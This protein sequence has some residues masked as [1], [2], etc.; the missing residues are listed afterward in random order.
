M[1]IRDRSIP[2]APPVAAAPL[3]EIILNL[4]IDDSDGP[5]TT[6]NQDIPDI[7]IKDL[8]LELEQSD[9][10]ETDKP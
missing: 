2:V 1:C 7:E 8:G 4:E 9:D 10:T 6:Q 5:L 3:D